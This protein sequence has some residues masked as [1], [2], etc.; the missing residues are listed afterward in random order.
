MSLN[1]SRHAILSAPTNLEGTSNDY[2][3]NVIYDRYGLGGKGYTIHFFLSAESPVL[4]SQ[5]SSTAT[6]GAQTTISASATSSTTHAVAHPAHVG[7]ISTFSSSLELDPLPTSTSSLTSACS[8]CIAQAKAQILSKSLLILTPKL[9][10][11][12]LDPSI[13]ALTTLHVD[14]VTTYLSTH[15]SWS[16]VETISGRI[17]DIARELPKTK[18]FVLGGKAKH[19][20]DPGRCSE[21][22]GYECLWGVTEGRA[23]VG[24]AGRADEGLHDAV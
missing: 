23:E 14:P 17:V 20:E 5:T 24:G 16:I 21:Y 11:H 15:L 4:S 3:I 9:V 6:S 19:H 7:T 2:I 22:E 10:S 8:N 12:A 13:P 1:A 18:V